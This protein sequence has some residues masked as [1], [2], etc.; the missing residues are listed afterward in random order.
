M[1]SSKAI[2]GWFQEFCRFEYDGALVA[3]TSKRALENGV[4]LRL[5]VRLPVSSPGQRKYGTDY[6]Y[7][8][9]RLEAVLLS[10]SVSSKSKQD[11]CSLVQD[12]C[13]S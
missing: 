5:F 1:C 4:D 3:R 10:R 2:D 6:L 11:A 8:A 13:C 7:N 12:L 9:T